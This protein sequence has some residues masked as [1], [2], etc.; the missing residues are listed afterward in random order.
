MSLSHKP[1]ET[2]LE[3][4][5]FPLQRDVN[6]RYFFFLFGDNGWELVSTSSLQLWNHTLPEFVNACV[7]CYSLCEFISA[8]DLMGLEDAVSLE[9]STLISS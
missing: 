5:I 6:W 1:R 8:A 7:C 4:L 2:S 3:K 9:L